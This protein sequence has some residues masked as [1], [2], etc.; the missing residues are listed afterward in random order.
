MQ[1]ITSTTGLKDAIRQLEDRQVVQGELLK[2]QF[3]LT[4]DSFK[5]AN[6]L[7]SFGKNIS[8]GLI[9]NILGI[10]LGLTAGYFSKRLIIG[11]SANGVKN[12]L[13]NI[14]QLGITG[15]ITK[16]PS[17]IKSIGQNIL[18]R[19]FSRKTPNY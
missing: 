5:P 18:H 4:F 11:S 17:V 1:L 7:K 8:P 19:I 9:G 16:K 13:G 15:I 12:L 14:L 10:S 6:L 2:E 3:N